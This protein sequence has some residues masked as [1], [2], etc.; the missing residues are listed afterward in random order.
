MATIIEAIPT[1]AASYLCNSDPTGITEEDQILVDEYCKKLKKER[2]YL[3]CPV[4]NQEPYFTHRPA[5]GLAC[6]VLDWY[7]TK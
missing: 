3:I 4:E 7:A 6:N 1:W 2:Y 5:F